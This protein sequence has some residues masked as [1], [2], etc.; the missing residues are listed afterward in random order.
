VVFLGPRFHLGPGRERARDRRGWRGRRGRLDVLSQ[1]VQHERD[2]VLADLVLHRTGAARGERA[3]RRRDADVIA[4]AAV[5]DAIDA[6]LADDAGHHAV[7]ALVRL[8]TGVHVGRDRPQ[9]MERDL[10]RP[11]HGGRV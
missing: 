9:V 6:V 4:L 5:D 2:R 10:E 1:V 11:R 7:L 8:A 3:A